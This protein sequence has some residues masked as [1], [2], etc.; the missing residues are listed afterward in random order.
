MRE[1]QCRIMTGPA[2]KGGHKRVDPKGFLS[3]PLMRPI[4]LRRALSSRSFEGFVDGFQFPNFLEKRFGILKAKHFCE[5]CNSAVSNA[6]RR[7]QKEGCELFH[8][9][10]V[11]AFIENLDVFVTSQAT[12]LHRVYDPLGQC[13]GG[14]FTDAVECQLFNGR[15]RLLAAI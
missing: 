2:D 14:D 4:R 13:L 3:R 15:L 12:Q 6:S 1:I 8:L 7:L 11:V 9:N 10:A 5:G